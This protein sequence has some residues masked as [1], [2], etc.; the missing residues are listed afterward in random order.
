VTASPAIS[1]PARGTESWPW[2]AA[3]GWLAVL[4]PFFFASYGF[5]NWVTSRR[6]NVPALYFDWERHIPFLAWT[7]VP[8]WSTDFLYAGSLAVCRTRR[9]LHTHAKRLLTAQLIAIAGFL[10]FPLHFTFTRPHVDGFFGWLF[11]E[12][13]GFDKPFN[14]APSLHLVLTTLLMAKYRQHLRGVWRWLSGGWMVLMGLSTLTTYQ[15]HFIDLPT[16]VWVGLLCLVLFPDQQAQVEFAASRDPRRI[17]IGAAYFA[18]F[19]LLAAAAYLVGGAGWL[20]LWPA[21]S[22]LLVAGIYWSGRS[23]LFRKFDGRMMLPMQWLL[24]PYLAAAWLNSRWWTRKEPRATEI[25]GGVW[26][27]RIP[28]AG[29]L[30]GF[31]SLVDATAELPAVTKGVRYRG[32]PMLDLL[33][34]GLD[35]LEAAVAAIEETAG[36]QPT[37]VCCALGYSR[38]AAAVVAWLMASGRADSLDAAIG[39]LAAR[40]PRVVL[41]AAHRAAIEAWARKRGLR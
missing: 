3:L 18:G 2:L 37:L 41:G 34:P 15:H 8:Y 23:S 19:G 29:D 33:A 25:A 39:M 7:I 13:M 28:S 9:E 10:L 32:I 30:E 20:L 38:S 16:G 17:R 4:A 26:L 14:Q 11:D 21:G 12:L 6:A 27:G 1:R 22:L 31:G 40:R 24:A 35:Q 36:D 5:A